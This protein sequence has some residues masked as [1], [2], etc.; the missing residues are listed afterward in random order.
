MEKLPPITE[1]KWEQ[2]NEFNKFIWNDFITNSTEL[3]PETL[4]AYYSNLRIWF[5]W[6]LDNLGNKQQ[7]DIKPLDFKR[8][9]NWMIGRGCSSSDITNKRSAVSSLNNY[10]D[11]YYRDD[12][13]A[14]RN[15]VNKS[16]K[17]P[18]KSAVHE[19]IPPTK[20]EMQMMIDTLEASNRKNKKELIAY[21]KF[22]FETGCR[23]AETR[24]ILKNIV[25]T[26]AIT[27]MVKTKDEDG[28]DI[29]KEARYYLTPKIRCK[30]RG[31]TGKQ[32]QLKFSDYSMD[33]FK[34]WLADRGEDDNEFMFTVKYGGVIKQVEKETFNNWSTT[35]F[36]PILGRRFHPHILREA[37]ATASVIEE[38]KNIE[39][40]KALLGHES[41][42]TTRGYVCG[43]DDEA[44][45]DELFV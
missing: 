16:I 26:P 30:G 15:F 9:Q 24:Q 3:S 20:A 43:L 10:I 7:T 45:A 32:R 44:E 39:A 35:I 22:T 21:L 27:K 42:T 38:G 37:R 11:I 31:V 17:K 28:N 12:Y 40:V 29:E 23:R 34:E 14:F 6:V 25:Q 33:A 18:E 8:F 13:P 41:S 36:E 5:V 2:V 1:E 19:K 4:K